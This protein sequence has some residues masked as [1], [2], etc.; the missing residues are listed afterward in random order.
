MVLISPAAR[1]GAAKRCQTICWLNVGSLYVRQ[2]KHSF[3]ES[4]QSHALLPII[5]IHHPPS[6]PQSPI[7][8]PRP[9]PPIS[10][11]CHSAEIISPA[12]EPDS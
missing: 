4:H 3:L 7:P 6:L 5:V 10:S 12:L 11:L 2:R 8:H 1:K 9:L